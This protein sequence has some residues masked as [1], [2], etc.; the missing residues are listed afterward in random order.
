MAN[1]RCACPGDWNVVSPTGCCTSCGYQGSQREQA[2]KDALASGRHHL[3]RE[4][5]HEEGV[6]EGFQLALQMLANPDARDT[7]TTLHHLFGEPEV[8]RDELEIG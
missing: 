7:A 3:A 5:G 6:R 1:E 4:I 2:V 8:E